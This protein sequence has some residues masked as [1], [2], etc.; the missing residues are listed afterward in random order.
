MTKVIKKKLHL[1]GHGIEQIKEDLP[2]ITSIL[3]PILGL[4]NTDIDFSPDGSVVFRTT[5]CDLWE[6]IKKAGFGQFAKAGVFCGNVHIAAYKG[7]CRGLYPDLR[8]EVTS[9]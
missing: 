4:A 3:G 9:T 6:G 5:Q 8:F 1:E 2:K 7:M